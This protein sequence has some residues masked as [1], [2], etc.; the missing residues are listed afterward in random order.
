LTRRG[1]SLKNLGP[2]FFRSRLPI[3]GPA[4]LGSYQLARGGRSA[5]VPA[6]GRSP[7]CLTVVDE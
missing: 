3:S 1:P 6:A 5:K 4:S 7:K 2:E